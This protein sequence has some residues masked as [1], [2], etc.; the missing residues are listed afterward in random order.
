MSK[1]KKNVGAKQIYKYSPS[2]DI[3]TGP[4]QVQVS[5]GGGGGIGGNLLVSKICVYP[6]GHWKLVAGQLTPCQRCIF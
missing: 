3:S 1:I 6:V 2:S 4:P 5:G